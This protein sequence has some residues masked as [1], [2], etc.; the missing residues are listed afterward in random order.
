M[1]RF[2]LV[3]IAFACKKAACH[4]RQELADGWSS[5]AAALWSLNLGCTCLLGSR[6]SHRGESSLASMFID[7][8]TKINNISLA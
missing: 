2:D 4:Q 3:G 7:S 6:D 5:R 1:N 8:D